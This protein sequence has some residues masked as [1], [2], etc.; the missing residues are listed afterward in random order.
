MFPQT[1]IDPQVLSQPGVFLLGVLE[2]HG[3][4][5]SLAESLNEALGLAVGPWHVGPGAN[6]LELEDTAGFGKSLRDVGRSVV[7]RHLMNNQCLVYGQINNFKMRIVK[8][9]HTL[10]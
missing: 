6:E 9:V 8:I 7:A 10:E 4:G 5:P 1:V 2:S 3:V